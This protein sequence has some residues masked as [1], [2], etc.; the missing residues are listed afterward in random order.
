MR[1]RQLLSTG[2]R[3]VR[4]SL[5]SP[6]AA[7]WA[8]INERRD[9]G[10]GL[11]WAVVGAAAGLL[12]VAIVAMWVLSSYFGVDVAGSISFPGADGWCDTATVGLGVHC[13]GDFSAIR[14]DSLF[15]APNAVEAVYPLS[16]RLVRLPFFLID[17]VAGF[18]TALVAY[19]VVSGVCILAPL[20]WAVK[21]ARWSLKPVVVVAVG[22]GTAPFL[23]LMDRGNIIALIVPALFFALLGLV[24]D[25][26]WMV[27]IAVIVA[28][29]VKPQFALLGF[30]LLALRHW[31]PALVS[32]GGSIAIVI[33]PF[34]LLGQGAVGGVSGWLHAASGWAKGHDLSTGWPTNASFPRVI[35]LLGHLGDAGNLKEAAAHDEL[36]ATIVAAVVCGLVTLVLLVAGRGLPPLALGIGFTTMASLA[37]PVSYGYYLVFAIPVVAIVFRL[38]LKGWLD[39][40]SARVAAILLSV[41]IVLGLTP[42]LIPLASGTQS[43]AV[44]L[45]PILAAYAWLAFLVALAIWG[46][47]SLRRTVQ[48]NLGLGG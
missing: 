30:A 27:A 32:L 16:T 24:R 33:L 46:A 38:G 20:F 9:G 34:G 40:R 43:I 13:F 17:R 12:G 6:G 10:T 4:A 39:L 25:R 7:S 2:S 1:F 22:V 29:S 42:L 44:S 11:G 41:A 19:V 47:L 5:H 15:A 8:W 36:I 14:F 3:T 45:V 26:P 18:Q 37:V 23:F 21:E 35:Y 31:W 48:S 28:S